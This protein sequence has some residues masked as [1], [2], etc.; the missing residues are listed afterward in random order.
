[1][2]TLFLFSFLWLIDLAG[3]RLLAWAL[4]LAAT[5]IV[6]IGLVAI[7]VA[8][9]LWSHMTLDLVCCPKQGLMMMFFS[10]HSFDD[11]RIFFKALFVVANKGSTHV[12]VGLGVAY[13]FLS[14]V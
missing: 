6:A 3:T 11:P 8:W 9:L 13:L 1:M 7:V 4:A 14:K 5:T 12:L 10:R 2:L